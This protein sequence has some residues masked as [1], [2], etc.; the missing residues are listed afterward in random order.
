M[1]V[2]TRDQRQGPLTRRRRRAGV[3]R[4]DWTMMF[5]SFIPC[6]FSSS[7]APDTSASITSRFHV[8]WTMPITVFPSTLSAPSPC[9]AIPF[10]G[11][12]ED[13]D[14]ESAMLDDEWWE[15]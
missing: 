6:R 5:S 13:D 12:A 3:P 8:E 1:G 7:T 11:A 10:S 15:D 2:G 14:D 4:T 9:S